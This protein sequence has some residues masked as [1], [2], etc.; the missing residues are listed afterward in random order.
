L[1][2]PVGRYT[3]ARTLRG[4]LAGLTRAAFVYPNPRRKL[5]EAVE[6]G[7]E[8]DT[9]LH[10][11][12]HM[13]AFGVDAYLHDARLT[14]RSWPGPLHRVAWSARELPLPW[15]LRGT[16]VVFTPLAKLL[17]LAARLRP[18]LRVV[19]MNQGLNLTLRRSPPTRR[20]L[21]GRSLRS[22]ARIVCLG[23]AQ[24]E[25]AIELAGLDPDRVHV[26]P[27]AADVDWYRPQ[28]RP[29]GVEP[30][31][32]TVGR[33][34]ARDMATF[35][36]AA[37]RLDMRVEVVAHERTLAGVT[38]PANAR[39]RSWLSPVELRDAYAGAACVVVVQ[40]PDSYPY[41]SESGGV[42]AICEAFA[43]ARPVV[44]TDRAVLRDYL[45]PEEL[46]PPEDPAALAEAIEAA[47]A[48]DERGARARQRAEEQFST[49]RF[50]ERLAPILRD[51]T[52]R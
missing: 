13:G 43:M 39:L 7:R 21:L 19:V 2:R 30:Y 1:C 17:P 6:A 46:V 18:S 44:A 5:L 20:A 16:D 4:R 26:I 35:A 23:E 49:R 8:P 12:N 32:L 29:S 11:L 37:E 45:G 33:D 51:S 52:Q 41:G 3:G 24:R 25:D 9:A 47:A 15:E 28:P 48:D 22:A 31:V 38:L 34:L 40:R 10:G 42:T 50:A 36:A 27:F 14:R